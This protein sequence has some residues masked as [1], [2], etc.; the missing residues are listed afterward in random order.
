MK[1]KAAFNGV[2]ILTLALIIIKILSAIYR[3]PY[4][5]I[6]GD[7][8]LYAYQQIYP[9]VA[10]G[11][12]LSMNAIPS[13]VTQNLG[14]NEDKYQTQNYSQVLKVIQFFGIA[15][16][17]IIF[18]CAK[19]L[20]YAMGDTHLTPMIQ[21]ASISFLFIGILGVLRGYY[22]AAN[23]MNIPAMSQVIE[24]VVRVGIIIIT[25]LLFSSL[26]WTIYQ[27]GTMAILASSLGF[28]ASSIFLICQKPFRFKIK[29]DNTNISWKR[30]IVSI[31]I[32]AVSQLIVILWQVIDSFTIIQTLKSIG[33][34]FKQAISDK[35][36]YD[37]GASFIQMGL[38]VT[39]TFSFALIPLLSDAIR[40]N[41]RLQMNRYANASLK[42]TILIST[43]AGIGLINLLPLM[44][45]VFFKTDQ[46]TLTLT[47]YMI[48]VI[49]VSLIMIDM[50]LLQAK[51]AIKPIMIGICAGIILKIIFNVVLIRLFGILGASLS[52][53]MSLIVFGTI[54]HVAVNAL[55]NTYAMKH[56][57]SKVILSMLVMSGVVQLLLFIITTHQRWTGLIELL[58][59][60]IIGI[61]VLI[62]F[63]M[64]FSV[65]TYRELIYLP[66]GEKLYR[67]MKGRRK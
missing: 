9:I 15:L 63:I 31:F 20:A 50:A 35:G 32:F 66:Y 8:G 5:N 34:P 55:Y 49:C 18:I 42:I 38:I 40:D 23:N 2:V 16:C 13:A 43:A 26:G 28:L 37:R 64:K 17:A 46:L 11:M 7:S 65:L 41:N 1:N 59:V 12:I 24:Q 27:A 45:S 51:H 48:T 53:V 3:I 57:L 22:Q 60:A 19:M 67:R 61:I 30:L 29:V 25:I 52:T 4:Q 6:L 14:R 58:I 62:I 56:Y 47:I 33:T 36:I 21:T 39:T 44:N 10:L 54:L